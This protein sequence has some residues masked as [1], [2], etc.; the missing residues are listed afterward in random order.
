[1]TAT[2][3]A[4]TNGKGTAGERRVIDVDAARQARLETLGPPAVVL[5][6]GRE[7]ELPTELPSEVLYAFGALQQSDFSGLERAMRALFGDDYD[8]VMALTPA[9]ADQEFLIASTFE[10]FGFSLP[11]YSASA[12]S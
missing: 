1:M 5:V 10:A 7:F 9:W 6:G 11:E 2:K 8:A 4:K 12:G 3:T